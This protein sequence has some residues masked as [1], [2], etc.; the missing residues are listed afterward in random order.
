MQAANKAPLSLA[1]DPEAYLE[2]HR[3]QELERDSAR[4]EELRRRDEEEVRDCTFAPR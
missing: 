1:Q 3:H 4:K 2:W